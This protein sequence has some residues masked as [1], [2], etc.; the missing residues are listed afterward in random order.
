MRKENNNAK[1]NLTLCDSYTYDK[2]GAAIREEM[3]LYCYFYPKSSD[4]CKPICMHTR[5]TLMDTRRRAGLKP[6]R[7]GC[8]CSEKGVFVFGIGYKTH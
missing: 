7:A 4:Q 3:Y 2:L 5:A 1:E 6:S 8:C